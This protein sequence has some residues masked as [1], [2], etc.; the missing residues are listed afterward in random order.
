MPK[1]KKKWERNPFEENDGLTTMWL[2]NH[3]IYVQH[4]VEGT[5]QFSRG[6]FSTRRDAIV[7]D[8]VFRYTKW[9]LMCLN[10]DFFF[11]FLLL[12]HTQQ[13]CDC[14]LHLPDVCKMLISLLLSVSITCVSQWNRLQFLSWR[15]QP[16][17]A[18][19]VRNYAS[20]CLWSSIVCVFIDI[21]RSYQPRLKSHFLWWIKSKRFEVW[22]PHL[23]MRRRRK[24]LELLSCSHNKYWNS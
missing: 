21:N 15:N 2:S 1:R 13:P 14:I 20:K 6:S 4:S 23:K 8:L 11:L 10:F 12:Y 19:R 3:K 24:K 17:S 18:H 5:M 16:K 7:I 9:F 22:L